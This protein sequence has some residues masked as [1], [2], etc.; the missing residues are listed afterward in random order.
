VD[1]ASHLRAKE[2]EQKNTPRVKWTRTPSKNRCLNSIPNKTREPVGKGKTWPR[3]CVF[4]YGHISKFLSKS[5][6]F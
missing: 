5:R 4:I 6:I 3:V 1:A 2:A